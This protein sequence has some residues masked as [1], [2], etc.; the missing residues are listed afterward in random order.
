MT[1]EPAPRPEAPRRCSIVRLFD[2][3]P[4]RWELRDFNNSPA[5]SGPNF[6]PLLQDACGMGWGEV[7]VDAGDACYAVTICEV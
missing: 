1:V 5:L 7:S 6:W 4:L 2:E 3:E